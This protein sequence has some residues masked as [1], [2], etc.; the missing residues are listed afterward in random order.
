[1]DKKLFLV[2]NA[3]L[4]PVWLWPWQEGAAEAVSTFRQAADF[5]E[6]FEG[7]IF[8]HNEAV[9]YKWIQE[10]DPPLFARIQKMVETGNWHIMGGWFLQPD[11]NIPSGESFVRQILTGKKYFKDYFG[12]E[13]QTAINFDPFGHTRGLVQILKKSGYNSYLFCRPDPTGFDLPAD[14][15][16]WVGYDGSEIQCFRAPDHYN[17]KQGKAAEKVRNWLKKNPD[18]KI[19]LMLWGIGNH[20]GGPSR[21]DLKDLRLL[22][23]SSRERKISHSTP[24]EYFNSVSWDGVE[25]PR[26]EHDLNPWAVGCYTTMAQIKQGH[27]KLENTYYSTEKM[28]TH[29]FLEGLLDYPEA[30]LKTAMEDLLFC[31]FHDILPGSSIPEVEEQ[32][33]QR[34]AH[35]LEILDRLKT[36]AFFS[37][38]SGQPKTKE[39]DYSFF[40]YNPHPFSILGDIKVEF[41]PAEPIH[42]QGLRRIPVVSNSDGRSVPSQLE[43]E[44]SNISVDWRKR[45]VFH[46][47]LKPSQMNRFTCHLE[48]KKNDSILTPIIEDFHFRTDRA[49]IAVN[50]NT[51]WLSSYI[52]DGH[53]YLSEDSG[54]ALVIRDDAD[55]WGMKVRGFRDV[56]GEFKLMTAGESAV[57]AGVDS[58]A[59]APVR[60]IEDGDARSIIEALFKFRSSSLV[61]RYTIPKRENGF[62]IDYRVFWNEKDRMLKVSFQTP[63]EKGTC[64]GQVAYGVEEYSSGEEERVGQKWTAVVSAD[65]KYALTIVN[66]GTYGFDYNKGEIRCSLLRSAAYAAHPMGEGVPIVPQDRMTPRIDQGERAFK[67]RIQGGPADDRLGKIDRESLSFNEEPMALCCSPPGTGTLPQAGILLT[68][69]NVQLTAVKKAEEGNRI[70][71]RIFEPSGKESSTR[72]TIPLIDLT[73]ESVLKP[74]EIKTL[75]VDLGKRE[76]IEVDLTEIPLSDRKEG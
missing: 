4:D 55:P 52:V 54:R 14:D 33:L 34:I 75:S 64:R 5:C 30:D 3:H 21:K 59:F 76:V 61:V 73:M 40:V 19:G 56:I 2:C 26:W 42:D 44:S 10:Y 23:E 46:A 43:K 22:M 65:R 57:L 49:E 35:G 32:A 25:L 69:E 71:F 15:F 27:R 60:L 50:P 7:F 38:L 47:E 62:G 51:G 48:V 18:K 31:Q 74:F 29:A 72:I 53:Q 37:L 39:G 45:V 67:F 16:I 66:S 24:E 41:Q 20:G 9:L 36:R 17:S 12:V 63:F 70:I 58:E 6:E 28:A 1:M 13:P 11:C 68:D 8:C